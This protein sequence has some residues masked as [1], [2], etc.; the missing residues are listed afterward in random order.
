MTNF[1]S[2]VRNIFTPQKAVE[3]DSSLL[4]EALADGYLSPVECVYDDAIRQFALVEPD[5]AGRIEWSAIAWLDGAVL[6]E[7]QNQTANYPHCVVFVLN[8][9]QHNRLFITDIARDDSDDLL[10]NSDLEDRLKLFAVMSYAANKSS[11]SKSLV[12]WLRV[13]SSDIYRSIYNYVGEV[14]FRVVAVEFSSLTTDATI[15]SCTVLK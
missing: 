10:I 6:E 11:V 13:L 3:E 8:Y 9:K 14:P 15:L 12:S 1:L 2:R 7:I 4:N 5:P